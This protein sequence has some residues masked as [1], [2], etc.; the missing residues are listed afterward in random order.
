MALYII[1]SLFCVGVIAIC[2][3]GADE[4]IFSAFGTRTIVTAEGKEEE[5]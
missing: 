1:G 4:S 5:N 3:A 2:Y